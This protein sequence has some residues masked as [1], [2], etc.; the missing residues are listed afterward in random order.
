MFDIVIIAVGKIKES[1]L[2]QG[3]GEYLKRLSPYARIVM[4]ELKPETFRRESDMEKS[5]GLEA[6]R[7]IKCLDKYEDSHVIILDE[8]GKQF[9]SESFAN[10]I[11]TLANKKIVFVVGGSLGLG[12]EILN[13]N[14]DKLALSQMTFTHEM[15]RLIL[16]EQIYRAISIIKEKDYHH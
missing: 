13:R 4:E 9:T 3:I 14:F 5:K 12:Q 6:E 1:Y 15:A 8:N 11:K 7:I 10:K 16:V 2:S